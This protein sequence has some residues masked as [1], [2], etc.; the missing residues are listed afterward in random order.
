MD[1]ILGGKYKNMLVPSP[2]V[3]VLLPC[4]MSLPSMP[5]FNNATI[6]I[7]FLIVCSFKC[8]KTYENEAELFSQLNGVVAVLKHLRM[9]E[10]F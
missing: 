4:M 10:I 2:R 6:Y 7:T 1:K 9:E 5:T 3:R 8:V